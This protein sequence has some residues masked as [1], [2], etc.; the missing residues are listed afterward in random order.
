MSAGIYLIVN[1]VS[2]LAY[3]GQS[4]SIR[5]RWAQHRC[6]LRSGQSSNGRVNDL[7]LKSWKKHGEQAF[8]FIVLE[9][10]SIESLTRRETYWLI[11]FR[12]VHG[13]RVA[14]F[15]GPV[16]NAWRGAKHRPESRAKM[17][18]ANK[19]IPKPEGMRAKLSAARTGFRH[20]EATKAKVRAAKLGS[21]LP[22]IS[23]KNNPSHRPENVAR[24]KADNPA[25]RADVRKK[26][27]E[28]NSKRIIDV[29]T[30]E[31]WPSLSAFAKEHGISVAAVSLHM[32]GKNKTCRGR[33]LNWFHSVRGAA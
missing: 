13:Y 12:D 14:N 25:K 23:G 27:G 21:K 18:A 32:L 6:V 26:I 11:E 33:T 16:D 31:S 20:S 30:K 24:M 3:I 22:S 2:R 7:L 9:E 17:S 1:T 19:G 5:N 4:Q 28:A 10:C 29:K 15:A 8:Q